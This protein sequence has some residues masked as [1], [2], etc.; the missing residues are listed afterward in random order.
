VEEGKNV[1]SNTNA[2]VTIIVELQFRNEWA[3]AA[4]EATFI[5]AG[6]NRILYRNNLALGVDPTDGRGS[7]STSF[8]LAVIL[9]HLVDGLPTIELVSDTSNRLK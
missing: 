3:G 8:A 1:G 6:L 4:L 9:G 5:F 2:C 7:R